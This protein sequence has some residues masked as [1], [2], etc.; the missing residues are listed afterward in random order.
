MNS[1]S[2]DWEDIL[3]RLSVENSSEKPQ[4]VTNPFPVFLSFAV[5][6][7]ISAAAIML[8]NM[9]INSAWPSLTLFR[10]GIGYKDAWF[11]AS[12]L[13]TLFI[14][15]TAVMGAIVRGISNDHD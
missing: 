7:S 4:K 9:V 5:V 14:V 6:M 15:K 8:L 10:P 11:M 2:N 13:W 3:A 1:K 12:L